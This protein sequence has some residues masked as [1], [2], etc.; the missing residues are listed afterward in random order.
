MLAEL[1][2]RPAAREAVDV[3]TRPQPEFV[4]QLHVLGDTVHA[5]LAAAAQSQSHRDEAEFGHTCSDAAD[6]GVDGLVVR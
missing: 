4:G 6:F 1:R 5:C 3:H 2:D